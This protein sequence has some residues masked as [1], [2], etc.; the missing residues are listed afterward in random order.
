MEIEALS[1]LTDAGCSCTPAL[2]AWK[3]DKQGSDMWIPGGFFLYVL[4][5]KVPGVNVNDHYAKMDREERDK[6][7]ASFKQ[8][9]LYVTHFAFV[10]EELSLINPRECV[11]CGVVHNDPA[12]RNLLWDRTAEKW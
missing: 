11:A 2:L 1:I 12:S 4:M 8:A 5:E 10:Q 9:W 7:R 3:K 6:L